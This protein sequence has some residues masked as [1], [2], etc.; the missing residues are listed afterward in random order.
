[1]AQ[2]ARDPLMTPFVK[3]HGLGNDFVVI[4]A[5]A[6]AFRPDA[7]LAAAIADRRQGVGFD[8]L[9]VM[10]PPVDVRAD[11]FMTI[12]NAD[13]SEAEAC[14]NGTRCV[15]RRVMAETGRDRVVIETVAGL[16]DSHAGPDGLVAVDMGLV[17]TDWDS[18]PLAQECDTLHVPLAAGPLSDPVACNVGNPH[19][20]FFV[21]DLDGVDLETFGPEL[22]HNPIFPERAN[23]GVLQVID[24]ERARLRVWERGVGETQACGS[25]ACAAAVALVRRD[26]ADR[27]VEIELPGGTLFLSYRPDGHIV[28]TGPASSAFVGAFDAQE[29]MR[30]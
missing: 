27:D 19:A 16:L 29:L 21:D 18:I 25:G 10:R 28:M 12:Y 13:G 15:A 2:E 9:L 7:Q 24:R 1:M 20:T 14:G 26:L 5:R 3:M 22:E 6:R 8:Q 17:K 30:R 23:I 11:V 4:D